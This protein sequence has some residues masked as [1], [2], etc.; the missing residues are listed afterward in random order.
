VKEMLLLWP[1][2]SL[3][4]NKN[5]SALTVAIEVITFCGQKEKRLNAESRMRWLRYVIRRHFCFRFQSDQLGDRS[6]PLHWYWLYRT[7][8]KLY[9]SL[10]KC[11]KVWLKKC[12]SL[13]LY[14]CTWKICTTMLLL[15]LVAQCVC[16][17]I[18][19]RRTTSEFICTVHVQQKAVGSILH[20]DS[21]LSERSAQ[22]QW[23]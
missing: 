5:V 15:L 19:M 9:Q 10:S 13:I 11:P 2:M 4:C 3:P 21:E 20:N 17:M 8:S 6:A 12:T 18:P 1:R 14:Y 16:S 23:T 22:K 7:S